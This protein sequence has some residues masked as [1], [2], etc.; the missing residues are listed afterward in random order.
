MNKKILLGVVASLVVGAGAWSFSAA[1][2]CPRSST[3]CERETGGRITPGA[4]GWSLY[5]SKEWALS[6]RYPSDWVLKEHIY[7]ATHTGSSALASVLVAGDGYIV[8][9]SDIGRDYPTGTSTTIAQY[10]VGG[11]TER[12]F[13]DRLGVVEYWQAMGACGRALEVIRP[14]ESKEIIEKILASVKCSRD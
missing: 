7:N 8:D 6:F 11:K 2:T 12:A 4:E 9:F 13:E 5:E 14:T 10:S 1:A 3:V